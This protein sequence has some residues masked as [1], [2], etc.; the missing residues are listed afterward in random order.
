MRLTAYGETD[1][2]HLLW[3]KTHFDC[4]DQCDHD[5]QEEDQFLNFVTKGLAPGALSEPYAHG[6]EGDNARLD[7]Q[8][9]HR[10]AA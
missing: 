3:L 9:K 7:R 2:A 4:A 10:E 5:V 6:S 1:H 8:Q